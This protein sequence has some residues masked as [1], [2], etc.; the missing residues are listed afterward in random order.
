MVNGTTSKTRPSQEFLWTLHAYLFQS[1]SDKG[2][3]K[4][5]QHIDPEDRLLSLWWCVFF[6][7]EHIMSRARL[8]MSFWVAQ[9]SSHL[10]QQLD[11]LER[12]HG[13]FWHRS[14]D[15]NSQEVL[16]EGDCGLAHVRACSY[17]SRSGRRRGIRHPARSPGDCG[18]V[19]YRAP[20]SIAMA[21]R[22]SF[23]GVDKETRARLRTTRTQK[24]PHW[25]WL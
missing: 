17:N 6:A 13:G 12:S 7:H 18:V 11:S 23:P 10:K 25:A 14:R 21:R 15:A 9:S 22:Y 1:K 2:C 3:T 4:K 24:K 16:G 20:P 19:W 8:L 5:Q